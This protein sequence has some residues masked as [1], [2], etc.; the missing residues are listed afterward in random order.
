LFTPH[1]LQVLDLQHLNLNG[2]DTSDI[3]KML[4][5]AQNQMVH[6]PLSITSLG[7]IAEQALAQAQY[8]TV[9]GTTSRGIFLYLSSGWVIFL[10]FEQFRGPLTLNSNQNPCFFQG[11]KPG[12]PVRIS[13]RTLQFEI[14]GIDDTSGIELSTDSSVLWSAPTRSAV[15]PASLAGRFDR[16]KY[17]YRKVRAAHNGDLSSDLHGHSEIAANREMSLVMSWDISPGVTHDIS[18]IITRV[19]KGLGLGEG[20]TPAGDDQALGFL[21]AVNRWGD[22]LNPDLDIPGINRALRQAACR[23]TNTLSANLIECASQGQADERLVLAL[24]GIMTGEPN[25]ETCVA[26]L[27]SWGHTS[28]VYALAGMLRAIAPAIAPAVTPALAPT[29]IQKTTSI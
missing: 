11:L 28:G 19:E 7:A 26:H 18:P 17:I 13:Q 10:S 2:C 23:K 5:I 3:I 25:P 29:I 24:D 1:G 8:A 15:S 6:T 22:L 16:I 21:L 14:W 12:A 20:L 4:H 27:L 9:W